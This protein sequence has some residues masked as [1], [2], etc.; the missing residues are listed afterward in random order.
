MAYVAAEILGRTLQAMRAG[1]GRLTADDEHYLIE[2][3]WTRPGERSVPG[4]FRVEDYGS[5]Y[6]RKL[7]D[8]EVVAI[9]DLAANPLTAEIAENYATYGVQAQLSV[10]LVRNGRLSGLVYVHDG[11]VRSWT[12]DE[13]AFAREVGER[14]W[15][16]VERTRAENALRASEERFR[17]LVTASSDVVYRM[18]PDWSVMRHLEGPGFIDGANE[19]ERISLQKYVHQD[20]QQQF[21]EAV[22]KAIRAKSI[23]E[24]EHRVRRSDGTTGWALSRAVPL[25]DADGRIVEWFGTASDMT[26]RKE[27]EEVARESQAKA[28]RQRRLYETILSSTPDLVYV[29]DLDYRLS[30]GNRALLEMWGRSLDES[31]GKTLLELGYEPWHATMHEHEMD[32]V[33]ATKQPVRG[34]VPFEHAT[35]GRRIYDYIFVPVISAEGEV[36]AVAGTTRDITD[37]KRAGEELAAAHLLLEAA[38]SAGGVYAWVW[39]IEQDRLRGSAE[40]GRL[41]SADPAEVG[42]GLPLSVFADAI[43]EDDRASVLEAVARA[44]ETGETYAADYRVRSHDGQFHWVAVRGHVEYDADGKPL[45][46]P[47]VLVDITERKEAENERE[48]LIEALG[49]ARSELEQRVEART[50]ELQALNAELESFNY[51]VSHD[52]R[53]PLRGIDGFSHLLLEEYQDS[54]DEEARGYLLRIS[55]AAARMGDL[56]N[57]L[58]NLSRTSMGKLE[59]RRVDLST[60]A[61]SV[62]KGLRSSDPERQ[63][64]VT[65]DQGIWA[66]GDR[67]SLEIVLENLLGN[68]WKFTQKQEHAS[69]DFGVIGENGERVFRVRDNGAGFDMRYAGKLFAPFQRVHSPNA[70]PGTGIGLAIVQRIIHRHGGRVWAE[71][72]IGKGASFYFTLPE[73]LPAEPPLADRVQDRAN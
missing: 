43:H 38:V 24:L 52:L 56:I 42:P 67:G 51:S 32:Q 13:I 19:P 54:L 44:V 8:G 27:A 59:R 50:A 71:S 7:Q 25:L 62:L 57:D 64:V 15:A 47:G 41:F 22:Q 4:E 11:R 30:F 1:Y 40:F 49:Q 6:A 21:A 45:R 17:A 33:L 35:L 66:Q 3:D 60:V 70:F 48:R 2:R 68:A 34:E 5:A 23:L 58:L 14:T 36:E 28:E 46:F 55:S 65:I 73:S 69:I 39:D 26:E 18:S 9:D 31:L 61:E 12:D 37:S 20:D 29:F 72:E 53:A 16:A 63:V 10:P